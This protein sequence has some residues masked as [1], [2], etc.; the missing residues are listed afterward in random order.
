MPCAHTQ[1]THSHDGY[2]LHNPYSL[3]VLRCFTYFCHGTLWSTAV[4]ART[5]SSPTIVLLNV[6]YELYFYVNKCFPILFI[7]TFDCRRLQSQWWSSHSIRA[8]SIPFR[9]GLIFFLL[10]VASPKYGDF[11]DSRLQCNSTLFIPL[12]C[13][14][15]GMCQCAVWWRRH[16]WLH[17]SNVCI[18]SESTP[19][20]VSIVFTMTGQN[21]R[22]WK[23][24]NNNKK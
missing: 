9:F 13:I 12:R 3:C 24:N 22:K 5:A 19:A 18:E 6:D 1:N 8:H 16:R 17:S 11:V 10:A 20:Y 21:E 2:S 23:K 15:F 14:Y 4:A 7:G